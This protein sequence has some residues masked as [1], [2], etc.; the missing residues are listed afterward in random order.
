MR[1]FAIL[2]ALC[3][4]LTGCASGD[5]TAF[6]SATQM[7]NLVTNMEGTLSSQEEMSRWSFGVAR[8]DIS[9]SGYTY[10]PPT[11]GNNWVGTITATGATFPFGT[12]N[13]SMTFTALDENGNPVDPFVDDLT[14][15]SQVTITVHNV[16][17]AGVSVDGAAL[18]MDGAYSAVTSSNAADSVATVLNGTFDV[19]YDE[20]VSSFTATDLE[21]TI[22]TVQGEVTNI[23]GDLDGTIDVPNWPDDA[24][25]NL[26]AVGS[27]LQIYYNVGGTQFQYVLDLV[28]L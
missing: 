28:D 11:A 19:N 12:G 17:F 23:V 7:D 1:R 21:L 24:N 22:D 9:V 5:Y 20:Y 27:Q 26:D 13:L 25:L 6:F 4:A 14:N 8:G 3:L 10:D 2:S 16:N 18:T 15:D